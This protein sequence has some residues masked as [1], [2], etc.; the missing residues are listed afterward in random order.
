MKKFNF[1]N[2]QFFQVLFTAGLLL[3]IQ[4]CQPEDFLDEITANSELNLNTDIFHIPLVIQFLDADPDIG[5]ITDGLQR[6]N[7]GAG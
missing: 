3:V 4:S 2:N 7:Y 5:P 6:K 1:L